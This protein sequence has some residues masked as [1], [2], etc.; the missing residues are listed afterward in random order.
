MR[1]LSVLLMALMCV[2]AQA[3]VADFSRLPTPAYRRLTL[4]PVNDGSTGDLSGMSVKP[5]GAATAQTLADVAAIVG[6]PVSY[7]RAD[8]P[9]KIVPPSVSSIVLAG[10]YTPGDACQG[11]VYKRGAGTMQIND[12]LGGLWHLEPGGI[13]KFECFG[14]RLDGLQSSAAA[15]DAAWDAAFVY[16][17]TLNYGAE[18]RF[19]TGFGYFNS[20]RVARITEG[21]QL[22][23]RGAGKR[24]TE[25][26]YA[27]ATPITLFKMGSDTNPDSASLLVEGIA[28]YAPPNS[29]ANAAGAR[30]IDFVQRS[31]FIM[32]D[33]WIV[34]YREGVKLVKCYAPRIIDTDFI[35]LLG[36]AIYNPAGDASPNGMTLERVG[37]FNSGLTDSVP[38][39]DLTSDG[40]GQGGGNGITMTGLDL[41]Y[42]Y[43]GMRFNNI[44]G[45][46]IH[47]SY[48]ERNLQGNLVFTGVNTAFDIRGNW[49]GEQTAVATWANL[50]RSSIQNNNVYNTTTTFAASAVDLDYS[51][52]LSGTSTITNGLPWN[53]PTLLNGWANIGGGLDVAGYRRHADGSVEIK[54]AITKGTNASAVA[55]NIPDGYRPFKQRQFT[56]GGL[57][58]DRIAQMDVATNGNVIVYPA[59][60]KLDGTAT[61]D[62]YADM[63]VRFTP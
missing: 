28:I 6:V 46:N 27:G 38:V 45:A 42:N 12:L 58:G 44:S 49:I 18:L 43:Q 54:G 53:T 16:M 2:T 60:K 55:F 13:A 34:G 61:A 20:Q 21:K 1:I 17:D 9:A 35:N 11:A 19:G 52:V 25:F 41:E 14:G 23:I 40:T 24:A 37:I 51:N 10:F 39:I 56:I 4:P 30:A 50:S 59:P 63:G 5:S 62:A 15:N 22:N 47:G 8:L 48:I 32:R 26:M 29:A 57:S 7:A 3:Q 36:R 33:V 31:G